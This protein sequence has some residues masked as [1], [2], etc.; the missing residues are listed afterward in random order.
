MIPIIL[1]VLFVILLAVFVFLGVWRGFIK[2]LVRS[3]K[4]ILSVLFAYLFGGLMGTFLKNVFFAGMIYS[5]V[6]GWVTSAYHSVSDTLDIEALLQKLPAFLVTDELRTTIE[7]TAGET[8]GEAL[9]NTV[10]HALADP[11]ATAVSNVLG[12]LAVFVLS[13]VLISVGVW[14]LR[15]LIEHIS[16]LERTDRIL[17]GVMGGL[18]ALLLLLVMTSLIKAF[19]ANDPIYLDTVI[20][21]AIGNSGILDL[22][23][24]LNVGNILS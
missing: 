5:T 4:V 18:T 21:R 3:V 8:G 9:I 10:S 23:G 20:V 11:L 14:F 16:L 17:G 22:L 19:F 6:N 13:L 1:D 7:A 24:F 12:Y 2:S 15:K